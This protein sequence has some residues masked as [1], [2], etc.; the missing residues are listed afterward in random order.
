MAHVEGDLADV[1]ADENL[2][3]TSAQID[4]YGERA[5]DVF[6]VTHKGG[7]LEDEAV[8]ERVRAGLL[9]VFSDN[10]TA[11]DKKAAQRGI[12]RARASVLR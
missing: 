3:L 12:A 8:S 7:K 2:A 10:E 5:T 11:F 4:G 6:Y 9:A 1:L